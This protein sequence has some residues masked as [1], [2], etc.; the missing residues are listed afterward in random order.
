MTTVRVVVHSCSTYDDD[1]DLDIFLTN[2]QILTVDGANVIRDPAPPALLRN[3]TNNS[4]NWL[5]VTLDGTPPFHRNGIGSRVVATVGGNELLRELHASSHFLTQGPS[6]IAHFGLGGSGVVS[7]LRAQWVNGDDVIL[8]NVSANQTVSIPSP[9]GT[10]SNRMP[11]VGEDINASAPSEPNPKEWVIEGQVIPDPGSG[12]TVSFANEGD[13][14]V[15]L[16]VFDAGG[17]TVIRREILPITVQP[18]T[19]TAPSITTEPSSITVTEPAAATFTVVATG[20]AP[21][22]YQWRR[23]GLDILGANAS[24]YTLDPTSVADDGASFDV[25]VTNAFG[26]ATS[27]A[28]ILTVQSAPSVAFHIN[29]GGPAYTS[30]GGD[31]F[32]A[33]KPFTAGDF[34][35][36]GAEGFVHPF[37]ITGTPDTTL[38]LSLRAGLATFSYAFDALP[39]GDYTVTLHFAELN[40]LPGERIFDVV[41]EDVVVLD[42]YEILSAAGGSNIAATETLS[43]TVTDGQ[44]NLDFVPVTSVH[45]GV[46]AISVV[47]Q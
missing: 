29:S 45:A 17:S 30:V 8:D 12:I 11:E 33:D 31:T 35:F 26:T 6:R 25:V 2:N 13:Q 9:A 15:E 16:R 20:T 18:A 7:E 37:P 14:D 19:G 46:F 34:G 44:L 40:A 5:K 3:D 47:Q 42:N 22:S 23:D 4:N 36:V 43:V 32:V 27:Q 41:A 1:G 10:L 28:A 38:Y 39:A 24:S 21:L